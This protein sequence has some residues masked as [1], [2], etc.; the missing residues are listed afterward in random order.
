MQKQ[1]NLVLFGPPGAGKGTQ[2]EKII[3]RYNLT[4][5]STGDLFRKHLGQ[6][7]ALGLEAQRYMD[8]GKLVPDQIVIGMVEDKIKSTKNT[9]GFI[10][11]GFPRTVPQAEALDELLQSVHQSISLMISLEVP[12]KELKQRLRNRAKVSGRTDDQDDAKIQTRIEEY[13][14]KTVPVATY[15]DNLD[16]LVIINGV[17]QIDEIFGNICNVLDPLNEMV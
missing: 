14:E 2:S 17:G 6:K 9:N 7:T 3:E 8:H 10:F 13:R 15:Y 16:K 12:E 11:D 1:L 5:I 4:H